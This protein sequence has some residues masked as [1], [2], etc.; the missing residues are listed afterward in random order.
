MPVPLYLSGLVIIFAFLDFGKISHSQ[1]ASWK[2]T[3]SNGLGN[4][5][6]FADFN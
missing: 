4:D 5:K 1:T 3:S 6:L 2:L